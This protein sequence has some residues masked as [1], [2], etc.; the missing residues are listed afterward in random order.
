M[1]HRGS[2]KTVKALSSI[3]LISQNEDGETYD[4]SIING[5][6]VDRVVRNVEFANES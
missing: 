3:Y 6:T 4:I 5:L 1:L 2:F